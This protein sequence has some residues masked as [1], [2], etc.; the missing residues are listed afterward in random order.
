MPSSFNHF[1]GLSGM[2]GL[3]A[4]AKMAESAKQIPGGAGLAVFQCRK[5]LEHAVKWM[6]DNDKDL[7]VP[8]DITLLGMTTTEEF[9]EI[10]P[11]PILSRMHMYDLNVSCIIL[12]LCPR[13]IFPSLDFI[14]ITLSPMISTGT[15]LHAQSP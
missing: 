7:S 10:C 3:I 1:N 12:I 11:E 14:T 2:E 6:Y 15:S 8:A 9:K 5:T 13:F 4:D